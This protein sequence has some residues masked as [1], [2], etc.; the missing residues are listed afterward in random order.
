MRTLA[1]ATHK[2]ADRGS[3]QRRLNLMTWHSR[4]WQ[5][6]AVIAELTVIN[7]HTWGALQRLGVTEETLVCLH[8]DYEGDDAE[9]NRQLADYL[10]RE[11]DYE[12]EVVSNGVTGSTKPRTVNLV[13]LDD[14]VR[15]MVIAG[16]ENGG[17]R[18]DG[19]D[20]VI[21]S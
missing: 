18:F 8:F 15:W 13:A 2:P 5:P 17:C 20:S 3:L 10:G 12:V 7:E 4:D 19:W 16:H 1:L 21:H 14:W 9:A 6:E 11:T